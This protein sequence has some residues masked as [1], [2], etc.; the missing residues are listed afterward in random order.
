MLMLDIAIEHTKK[1]RNGGPDEAFVMH[2][3]ENTQG[4]NTGKYEVLR[5][6]NM[7]GQSSQKRSTHVNLHQ[8][9]ELYAR[10]LLE[11]YNIRLRL[12]P[13]DNN[14][15]TAPPGK[16]VPASCI[17]SGSMFDR[18]V[19]SIDTTKPVSNDLKVALKRLSINL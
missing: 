9:A 19:K 1:S 12:R 6:I 2:P 8:M 15:P 5:S 18:L 11:I 14:Y 10:G 17:K 3:F 7:T 13:A 16:R 4:A